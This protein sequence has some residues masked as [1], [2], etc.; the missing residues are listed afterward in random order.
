ME[1]RTHCKLETLKSI[2]IVTSL[3]RIQIS[4]RLGYYIGLSGNDQKVV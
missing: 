3:N 1:S 4:A 2:K